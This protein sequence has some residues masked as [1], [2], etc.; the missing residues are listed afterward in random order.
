[1]G[2][3]FPPLDETLELLPGELSPRLAETV[4]RLGAK[5]SFAEAAEE[6][7]RLCGVWISD[8]TVR[9]YTEAAGRALV[10]L[11]EE[12]V[13]RL[14]AEYPEPPVGPAQQQVSADGAMVPLV[15]GEWG[16]V[17]TL[18]VG[19]I[20]QRPTPEGPVAQTTELSYLSMLADAKTFLCQARGEVHRRGVERAGQRPTGTRL[21]SDG[22]VWIQELA[23]RY[24]PDAV[25]ILD[26]P[27]AMEHLA[28][29]VQASLGAEPLRVQTWLAKQAHALKTDRPEP[30]LAALRMLPTDCARDPAA[31][32]QARDATLGYLEN[33]LEHLRYA[34]FQR[35]G[36][37]I[38]SGAVESACKLV[39][40]ARLKGSGRH[41]ARPNVTPMAALR[42]VLCS[43]RWDERWPQ[44]LAR[45]RQQASATHRLRLLR[46]RLP[47]P[48]TAAPVPDPP[49][50][51]T[52][53]RVHLT[54]TLQR[55]RA[56]TP[57]KIV[58]GRPTTDHPLRRLPIK[59][60]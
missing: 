36:L 56:Q 38:G 47:A 21:I 50:P 9:S 7:Q 24:R 54:K 46:R 23:D 35:Q 10:Q 16:E 12:E 6:V 15:H 1:M 59:A 44:L 22:S 39:V 42:A 60:S 40:E 26:Y 28:T 18:A 30:V 17:K 8:D 49:P 14:E 19:T 3:G 5:L 13:A 45:W 29:A 32:A 4:A 25:R 11:Q 43:R 53:P 20:R 27:H 51:P 31:A 34:E 57:P 41:W 58:G 55:L 2:S 33:R 52:K 48:P 37:P